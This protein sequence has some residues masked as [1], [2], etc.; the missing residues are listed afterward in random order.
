M[1]LTPSKMA[2]PTTSKAGEVAK[3]LY[4]PA[5]S[6]VSASNWLSAFSSHFPGLW[7]F[8]VHRRLCVP[9]LVNFEDGALTVLGL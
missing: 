4:F 9:E 8:L 5:D 1:A 2:V 3:I 7:Y 6:E